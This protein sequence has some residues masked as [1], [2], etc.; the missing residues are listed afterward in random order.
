MSNV[1]ANGRSCC[2]QRPSKN[3]KGDECDKHRAL[4]DV[5]LVLRCCLCKQ[6]LQLLASGLQV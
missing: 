2:V 3:W 1:Q 6:I 4:P 5:L